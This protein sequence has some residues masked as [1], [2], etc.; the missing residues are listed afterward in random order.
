[1]KL[2]TRSGKIHDQDYW[3][4]V[5]GLEGKNVRVDQSQSTDYERRRSAEQDC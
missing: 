3:Y 4:A 1:M 2:W 5:Q